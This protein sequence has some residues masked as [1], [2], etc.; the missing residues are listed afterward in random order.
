MFSSLFSIDALSLQPAVD[1]SAM[2]LPPVWSATFLSLVVLALVTPY[3]FITGI[4]SYHFTF[5]QS[6]HILRKPD[7][8]PLPEHIHNW[9]TALFKI[10][11]ISAVTLYM[12]IGLTLSLA[13]PET[14]GGLV[15]SSIK[16]LTLDFQPLIILVHFVVFDCTMWCIHYV[17]HR[18]RWLYIHTHADHHD[19]TSPT[20]VVA[21]T[22]Y[23]PD[24]A[25]LILV[26]LHFTISVVPGGN[27]P[28]VFIFSVLSLFHLHCIH[29]E[30]QHSWD[31]FF[32]KIGLCN[33]WDHHVHHVTPRF[34]LAHFFPVIDKL[35]GTYR[36]PINYK[37]IICKME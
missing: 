26:P 18:W 25:L 22:G 14:L 3:L 35:M 6:A 17:Q 21:L 29:S 30:F 10:E 36:D 34:N 33:S 16:T 4:Y 27:F 1:L 11:G 9:D 2:E 13:F 23:L 28:T 5:R 7:D 8:K 20:M 37:Q 31:P 32:R 24:T 12:G 15:P 19:I